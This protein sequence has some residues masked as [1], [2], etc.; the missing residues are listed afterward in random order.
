M[1]KQLLLHFSQAEKALSK[2]ENNNYSDSQKQAYQKSL[3][4]LLEAI[5]KRVDSPAVFSPNE[6]N[7]IKGEIN[8]IF[9]SLEFL[10]SSIL[11]LIPY[12]VVSCLDKALA[13]W[14]SPGQRYII[15]TSLINNAEA[16]GFDPTLAQNEAF[17]VHL[18]SKY[19]IAFNGRLVQINIPKTLARD[20]LISGIHYHELG[21]FVDS[22]Y[23]ITNSVT[24]VLFDTL[25][26]GQFPAG[27]IAEILRFLPALNPVLQGQHPNQ[28]FRFC[29][30]HVAEYFCDLF[31]AQYVGDC[32]NNH[33]QYIAWAQQA[34][35][36]HPATQ[37]RIAVISDFLSGRPNVI[38]DL[39]NDAL[40]Q[41]VKKKLEIRHENVNEGDFY[42]FLPPIIE[43]DRQL[44]GIFAA[45]V[46][47]WRSNWDAFGNKMAMDRSRQ[48]EKMYTIINNLIEKSV[49][50][51]IVTQKW[52]EQT[53]P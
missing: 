7:D 18:E 40:P 34:G 32:S 42:A 30:F 21:H 48:S 38:V 28:Y 22:K 11:N 25:L 27:K 16:F 9:K 31:A 46:R 19:G 26:S 3:F 44:H 52:N 1:E 17:Y 39:L 41:I 36:T 5:R 45:G 13:D 2:A 20:Y 35:P 14:T 8:F 49:G 15:V 37:E 33:L 29:Q 43:N 4:L 51:Y 53:N 6:I 10:G 50:N 12:E 47:V 24:K 23:S